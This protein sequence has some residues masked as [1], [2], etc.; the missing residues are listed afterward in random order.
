MQNLCL[1]KVKMYLWFNFYMKALCEAQQQLHR[2]KR[3]D[4]NDF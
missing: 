1:P 3:E 4:L 2:G